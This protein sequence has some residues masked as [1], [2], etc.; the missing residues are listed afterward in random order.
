VELQVTKPNQA[1]AA[2][3]VLA[4]RLLPIKQAAGYLSCTVWA[5][6]SLAWN[7]EV[8]SMKIGN[9]ILFDKKDLDEFI[10]AQKVAAL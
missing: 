6:R 7:R 1:A 10:E 4:P 9:R 3:G 5:V 8:P 2:T